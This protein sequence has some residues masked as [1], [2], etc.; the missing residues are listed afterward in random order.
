ME[1]DDNAPRRSKKKPRKPVDADEDK[2]INLQKKTE[3]RVTPM[4]G[5]IVAKKRAG[6]KVSLAG[7]SRKSKIETK[8]STKATTVSKKAKST[9]SKRMRSSQEKSKKSSK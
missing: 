3:G 9:V 2:I 8:I 4:T 7:I 5:R 6:K 1:T